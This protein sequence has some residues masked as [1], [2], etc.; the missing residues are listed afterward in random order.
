MA[1]HSTAG[2]VDQPDG[3]GFGDQIA[4]GQHQ[5]IRRARRRDGHAAAGALS[6]QR[7]SG[8]GIGRDNSAQL[9]HGAQGGLK[10]VAVVAEVRLEI[11]RDLPIL[12]SHGSN[13]SSA[14]PIG[15]C[16]ASMQMDSPDRKAR[17]S[18]PGGV[19]GRRANARYA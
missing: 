11:E 3:L 13:P 10:V 1:R 16:V 14:G 4:D 19:Q 7:V 17:G 6:A 18:A 8:E 15:G 9:N 2:M 12:V 5:A